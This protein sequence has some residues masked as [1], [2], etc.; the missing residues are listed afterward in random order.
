MGSP[1]RMEFLDQ[2]INLVESRFPLVKLERSE[3]T[4]SIRINGHWA[5]LENLYRLSVQH[6]GQLSR[7]VERWITELL[8]ASEGTP[9]EKASFEELKPRILP[10]VLGGA[11][12][13][14]IGA[15]T[16]SQVLVEGLSVAYAVDSEQTI[17]Y[18]S[19]K[20]FDS[21]K[22]AIDDLHQVALTNLAAR[23]EA[24]QAHAGQDEEGNVNLVLI[25]TMDG[26]DASR[27]LL[28]NLHDR[29]REHLGSPFVAGI[30]NRDI[31]VCFR[32]DPATLE[33]M[34][35]QIQQDYR[36]MPHQVADSLFLL[37][38]DGIA[39]YSKGV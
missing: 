19:R 9:D 20:L 18:I 34:S 12:G 17:A 27:I 7:Q 38:A 32:D 28:P 26:Y 35:R 1:S 39:P 23:S 14:A 13:G 31:L 6:P 8:R 33:R 25:Q 29:L 21:W 11:P 5:S 24:I 30:P 36:T 3:P 4:F 10:M 2:V 16:V 22:M 37:T 15:A